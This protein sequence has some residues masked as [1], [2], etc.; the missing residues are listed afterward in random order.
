MNP[1]TAHLM[2]CLPSLPLAVASKAAIMPISLRLEVLLA[3]GNDGVLAVHYDA[4]IEAAL[5]NH[6]VPDRLAGLRL[7]GE[8]GAIRPAGQQQAH[9]VD[10]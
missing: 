5:G 8:C 7:H 9:P 3:V 2:F 1:L 10:R 4:G 6:Q